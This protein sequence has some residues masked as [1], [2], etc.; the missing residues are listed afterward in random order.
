MD[1]FTWLAV[2]LA[3]VALF[4]VISLTRPGLRRL[5]GA[6][7][8]GF[9]FAALA[10]VLDHVAF[11]LALW[12]YPFTHSASGPLGFYVAAGL[13][14]GAGMALIG[15]RIT[16]RFGRLGGLIFLACFVVCGPSRDE[17][18]SALAS[19]AGLQFLVFAPGYVPVLADAL[20]WVAC[21]GGAL[22]VM[23]L[24]AGPTQA[25]QVGHKRV[26]SR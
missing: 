24:V 1:Q 13:F 26:D 3:G 11:Q 22:L 19:R 12:H 21:V 23:R 17:L 4:V 14:Y 5:F 8:A 9:I 18:G 2:S 6:L 16:R 20:C 7:L 25:V 15:W 10:L